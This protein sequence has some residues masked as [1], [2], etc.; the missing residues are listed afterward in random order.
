M[1]RARGFDRIGGCEDRCHEQR[2]PRHLSAGPALVA[3]PVAA[4]GGDRDAAAPEP[5][6]ADARLP[7][8]RLH[9]EHHGRAGDRI[10]AARLRRGGHVEAHHRPARGHRGRA[11][12]ADD[13]VRAPHRTR[14]AGTRAQTAKEGREAGRQAS[15]RQAYGG[16]VAADAQEGRSQGDVRRRARPEL[17]RRLLPGCAGQD[18]QSR[19]GTRRDRAGRR[20]L[21]PDRADPARGATAR[22]R[23]RAGAHAGEDRPIQ[24]L[25]GPQRPHGCRKRRRRDRSAADRARRR[26]PP[27]TQNAELRPRKCITNSTIAMSPRTNSTGWTMAPPA[28]AIA[29][30]TIP[31]ISHNIS[32]SLSWTSCA[33]TP[34]TYPALDRNPRRQGSGQ[35]PSDGQRCRRKRPPAG[36]SA[37]SPRMTRILPRGDFSPPR[38]RYPRLEMASL[39]AST[40]VALAAFGLTLA[41]LGG[42]PGSSRGLAL[43]GAALAAAASS[44]L[45]APRRSPLGVFAFT[46]A[47]SAA[48]VGLGY[49]Q[50]PP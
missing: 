7:A 17:P 50:G 5:E 47:A 16:A 26:N 21:L 41:L 3:Q 6:A 34:T 2:S 30:R 31:R 44:P 46:T 36:T 4:G 49:G 42:A 8:R 19:P 10:H 38:T 32:A 1:R 39:R 13:R 48:L 20:E 28:M 33:W 9:D 35:P 37:S 27:L 40:F 29:S 18:P 45:V 14:P 25:D 11:A 23:V 22:L 43:F 15:G 24:S 12:R